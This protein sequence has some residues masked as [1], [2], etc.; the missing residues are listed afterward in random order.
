MK[1]GDDDEEEEEEEEEYKEEKD[2]ESS[3]SDSTHEELWHRTFVKFY[4]RNFRTKLFVGN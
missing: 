1:D 2:Q 4:W 3:K